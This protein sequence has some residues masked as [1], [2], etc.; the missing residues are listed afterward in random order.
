MKEN[1]VWKFSKVR[2]YNTWTAAYDGGW[3]KSPGTRLPGPSESYPPDAPPTNVFE[4]VPTVYDIPF[5]Y[6]PP[7]AAD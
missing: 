7:S 4:M 5:H 3:A 6:A 2:A 1:G